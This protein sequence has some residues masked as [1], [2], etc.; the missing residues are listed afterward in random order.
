MPTPVTLDEP[1]ARE[2]GP[3]RGAHHQVDV[4]VLQQEAAMNR[5]VVA[6]PARGEQ[7]SEGATD[8]QRDSVRVDLNVSEDGCDRDTHDQAAEEP[9]PPRLGRAPPAGNVEDLTPRARDS[10]TKVGH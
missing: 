2:R 6:E 7:E 9:Q 3:D 10:E 5:A 4:G 8:Q 1:E